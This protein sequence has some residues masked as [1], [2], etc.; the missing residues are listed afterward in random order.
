MDIGK[1][2]TF[3]FE[4]PDWLR[5]LGLGTVVTL[6]GILLSPILIGFL[7]ILL[8]MGYG[9]DV[10]KNVINGEERP[11]PEW[12][13]WGGFLAR[14]FKLFAATFVW[15]LPALILMLPIIFGSVLIDQSDVEGFGAL[16]V[17]CGSCLCVLWGLFITVLSPAIYIQ[18][19][20]TNSFTAAFQFAKIWEI[21]RRNIG[22]VIIAVLLYW[23]ASFIAAIA[24]PLGLIALL[25]GVLVTMPLASFWALL[26]EAHLYGQ[27]AVA[28]TTPLD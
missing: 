10:L 22:N 16:L 6:A 27:V 7:A 18:V 24:A 25:I 13:D 12:E 3:M 23:V 11:L 20:R 14:G 1:S 26:V 15:A 17:T 8:I 19:A 2:F 21:T 9:L 4:D 5:K 28:S